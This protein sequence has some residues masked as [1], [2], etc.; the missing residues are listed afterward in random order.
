MSGEDLPLST[1]ANPRQP[2]LLVGAAAARGLGIRT[3][4]DINE[5]YAQSNQTTPGT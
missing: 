5:V 3:I 1:E 4:P 2:K